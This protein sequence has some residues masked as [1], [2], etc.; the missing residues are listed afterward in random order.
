MKTLFI[1]LLLLWFFSFENAAA[2]TLNKPQNLEM[3][4]GPESSSTFCSFRWQ[5][6]SGATS[7]RIDVA[8]DSLFTKLL[9]GLEN[10]PVIQHRIGRR[11]YYP[12]RG[13]PGTTTATIFGLRSSS[14]YYCRIRAENAT[15][16]S[17]NST[18]LTLIAL[19]DC[20][21]L[22]FSQ[23]TDTSLS[24]QWQKTPPFTYTFDGRLYS[25]CPS[26]VSSTVSTVT[27]E[28]ISQAPIVVQSQDTYCVYNNFP[29]YTSTRSTINTQNTSITIQ[30]LSPNTN[31]QISVLQGTTSRRVC[32][33][34][35][36]PKQLARYGKTISFYEGPLSHRLPS[37]ISAYYSL[38]DTTTSLERA[39]SLVQ[40][41]RSMG[42][43]IDTVW[44]HPSVFPLLPVFSM[45]PTDPTNPQFPEPPQPCGFT[46][47]LRQKDN[48]ITALGFT[49]R[50][51]FW[52]YADN[53][54]FYRYILSGTT[55]VQMPFFALNTALAI[56]PNPTSDQ[57]T[58][59]YTLRV[60]ANMAMEVYN[61]LGHRVYEQN[62][63]YQPEGTYTMPLNLAHLPNGMYR[64][65]LRTI[66]SSN[67]SVAT[68][69]ITIVK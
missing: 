5:L 6:V 21:E 31:Y 57:T 13:L 43:D 36:L 47:K 60:S 33:I 3:L 16:I 34:V 58:V 67:V 49:N 2:Q 35:T 40:Q 52:G 29:N 8:S 20:L 59:H 51:G 44:F 66:G 42:I 48:R 15:T 50:V 1:F 69:A 10:I 9:P 62:I 12:G 22:Q 38:N 7:Y 25:G 30:N 61:L 27:Y 11:Y 55:S 28:P 56:A 14:L 65:C 46:I 63:G 37:D 23:A 39:L 53:L 4:L 54:T 24:F 17:E 26:T 32:G 18:T 45:V 19:K 68:Q 64:L 41:A